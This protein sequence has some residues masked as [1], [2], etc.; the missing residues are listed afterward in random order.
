MSWQCAC[1]AI[2]EVK[3]L[4]ALVDVGGQDY[5]ATGDQGHQA[6]QVEEVLAQGVL[7]QDCPE[8]FQSDP[9]H[10]LGVLAKHLVE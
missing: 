2:H 8:V 9:V 7:R 5:M 6:A 4:V 3:G 10:N 1:C